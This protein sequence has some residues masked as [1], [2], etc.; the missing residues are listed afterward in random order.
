[1]RQRHVPPTRTV[2]VPGSFTLAHLALLFRFLFEFDLGPGFGPDSNS[3]S[4]SDS[5]S[6]GGDPGTDTGTHAMQ[7]VNCRSMVPQSHFSGQM[8]D[9]DVLFPVHSS[10]LAHGA[11]EESKIEEGVTV[12]EIWGLSKNGAALPDRAIIFVRFFPPSFTPS[13]DQ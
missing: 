13:Q 11:D 1:M 3:N 12:K 10:R 8:K 9:W 2:A 4:N 5:D 6:D 7:V